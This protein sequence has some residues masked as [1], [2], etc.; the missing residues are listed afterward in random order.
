MSDVKL[1][2]AKELIQEKRYE[3]A[4]ALLR[5]IDSPTARNWLGRLEQ[6]SPS[7]SYPF[8]QPSSLPAQK[9][10]RSRAAKILR[11]I[12]WTI[13]L[14]L[15]L[16][17]CLLMFQPK[18]DPY[19]GWPYPR[20][21]PDPFE[22]SVLSIARS[23]TPGRELVYLV[24]DDELISIGFRLLVTDTDT[25]AVDRI[26][27]NTACALKAAGIETE[28]FNFTGTVRILDDEG[29]QVFNED[30]YNVDL[31]GNTVARINCETF[32]PANLETFASRYE[33]G[34]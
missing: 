15:A 28:M 18:P 33:P 1:A 25:S 6:M 4:K 22:A 11:A 34:I 17:V 26:V 31:P 8:P 16:P 7:H 23:N 29:T 24:A 12:T 5:T 19:P 14:L 3:E 20:S 30:R 21:T 9:P 13:L 10:Q 2:A 32:D 27:V